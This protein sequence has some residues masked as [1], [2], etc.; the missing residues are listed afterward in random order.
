MKTRRSSASASMQLGQAVGDLAHALDAP[1]PAILHL[2][3]HRPACRRRCRKVF[4]SRRTT[5]NN[6]F[7][8]FVGVIV[9]GD[10]LRLSAR[11]VVTM[12]GKAI[13]AQPLPRIGDALALEQ[14]DD[15]AAFLCLVIKPDTLADIDTAR[16]VGA[17][18]QFRSRSSDDG[19][20][21][22]KNAGQHRA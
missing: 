11:A 18:A 9:G 12:F 15:T 6:R 22:P 2:V 3:R 1:D 14:V 8:V 5:W 20:A 21:R 4:G 19:S 7:A 17:P 16:A 10:E 13:F